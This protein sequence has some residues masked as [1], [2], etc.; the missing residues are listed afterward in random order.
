MPWRSRADRATLRQRSWLVGRAQEAP[1]S[2]CRCEGV[3]GGEVFRRRPQGTVNEDGDQVDAIDL[4]L[5][6]GREIRRFARALGSGYA[7]VHL[8]LADQGIVII[9]VDGEH[10]FATGLHFEVD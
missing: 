4:L 10:V 5:A 6:A 3:E 7:S 8:E 9:T 2:S 1:C